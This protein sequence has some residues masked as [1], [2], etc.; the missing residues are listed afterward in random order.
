MKKTVTLILAAVAML[1]GT[2]ARAQ[3]LGIHVGYAPE[4]IPAFSF[5]PL[6]LNNPPKI[7]QGDM[8]GV[9]LG[10]TYTLNFSDNFGVTAGVNGRYNTRNYQFTMAML[11][12]SA[13]EMQVV[14]DVPVLLHFGIP[15]SDYSRFSFYG[16]PLVSYAVM[17]SS[18]Y[19]NS[20]VGEFGKRDWY[21]D[22]ALLKRLNVQATFGLSLNVRHIRIFGGYVM[23]ILNIDA[24]EHAKTTTSGVYLGLGYTF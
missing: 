15:F 22:P 16:G 18:T 19:T 1:I 11:P 6:T 7:V 2:G 20:L 3:H 8:Q 17:G 12:S 24:H 21:A 10:V 9:Y 5:N 14:V 13:K 4:N 23:G